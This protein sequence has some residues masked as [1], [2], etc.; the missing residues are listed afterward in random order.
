M[1]LTSLI[2]V[3]NIFGAPKNTKTSCRIWILMIKKVKW[4]TAFHSYNHPHISDDTI[5]LLGL[6]QYIFP[7]DVRHKTKGTTKLH[8]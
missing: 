5:S 8:L 6:L 1:L 2:L 3:N 7:G 4:L